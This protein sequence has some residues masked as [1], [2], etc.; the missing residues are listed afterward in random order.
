MAA[1]HVA[2]GARGIVV[3]REEKSCEGTIGR[4]VTEEKIDRSQET[5]RLIQRK[6]KL[7]AQIGLKIRH[8]ESR[9]NSLSC[10]IGD[11]ETE[12]LG[13]KTEEVI[14]I[15]T[16]SARRDAGASVLQRFQKRQRLRK[17]P[18]LDLCGDGQ[19][20][21]DAA[22]GFKFLCGSAALALNSVSEFVE[23]DERECVAIDIAEAGGNA[24]P[25]GSFFAKKHGTGQSGMR[26]GR[27]GRR[28][29]LILD[30]TKSRSTGKAD[31]FFRPLLE[32]RGDVRS[33]ENDLR[34]AANKFVLGG[35]GLGSDEGQYGGAVRRRNSNPTLA[36]LQTSVNNE[37]EAELVKVEAEAAIDVANVDAN[38]VDAE[39]GIDDSHGDR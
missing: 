28:R 5:L 17:E 1:I 4:I 10:N 15:A 16:H 12:T 8:Q 38:G 32:F 6:R 19:F 24:A 2:K 29:G 11:H 9:G 18:G 20:L 30:T 25:N 7:A 39:E 21:S 23:A 3:V 22:F 27:C 13:A 14:V 26:R 37:V 33:Y 36:G 31:T 34:G 35:L